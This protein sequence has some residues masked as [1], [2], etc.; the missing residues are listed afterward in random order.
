[1][2]LDSAVG[3]GS[4]SASSLSSRA[5]RGTLSTA[6]EITI[7]ENTRQRIARL[8]FRNQGE[9]RHRAGMAKCTDDAPR[10]DRRATSGRRSAGKVESERVT[11]GRRGPRRPRVGDGRGEADVGENP[12]DDGRVL[13]RGDEALAAAGRKGGQVL[14]GCVEIIRFRRSSV[15]SARA[16]RFRAT[17]ESRLDDEPVTSTQRD[18]ARWYE[19]SVRRR[20]R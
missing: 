8:G 19:G 1:M 6:H 11:A 4:A 16:R 9:P 13:D 2:R 10:R 7:P 20:S 12:L 15:G 18:V 3:S 17:N 5:C 14:V